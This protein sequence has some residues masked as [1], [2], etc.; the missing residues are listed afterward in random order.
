MMHTLIVG[1]DHPPHQ[2]DHP[3]QHLSVADYAAAAGLSTATVRRR[4]RSGELAA[5]RVDGPYGPEW[6]IPT[7]DEHADQPRLSPSE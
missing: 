3:V 4:I 5:V 7:G 6:R 2:D 1:D